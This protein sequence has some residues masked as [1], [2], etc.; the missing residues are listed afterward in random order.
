MNAQLVAEY[1]LQKDVKKSQV[2]YLAKYEKKLFNDV[3]VAYNNGPVVESIMN[4]YGSLIE[5]NNSL[6]ID[7]KIKNFLDKI[8]MSLENVSY[9]E[10]IEITLNGL[11]CVIRHIM[12]Q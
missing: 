11:N 7:E 12:R 8:Y 5:K 10:L 4:S 2:V 3:F 6:V 1:F 9:E